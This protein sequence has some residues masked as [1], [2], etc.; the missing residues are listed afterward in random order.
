MTSSRLLVQAVRVVSTYCCPAHTKLGR[1]LANIRSRAKAEETPVLQNALV[2]KT[3]PREHVG[4]F[5]T[6]QG[7][8]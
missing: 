6:T 7:W 5:T 8:F 2:G 3:E 1:N 4:Y